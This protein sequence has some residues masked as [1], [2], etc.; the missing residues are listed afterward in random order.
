MS[1]VSGKDLRLDVKLVV[2]IAIIM[3]LLVAV[4]CHWSAQ[5]HQEQ[6]KEEL[7]SQARGFAQ[8]MDA[9]WKFVDVN[10]DLINYNFAGE[11]EYKQLHCSVAAKSVAQLFSAN[12]NYD[13]HYP[14]INPRNE[15]DSP[16]AWEQ[17]ALERFAEDPAATEY[18][19]LTDYG[20]SLSLRYCAPLRVDEGCL[21]CHGSPAGEIDITGYP[22][23]GWERGDLAGAIS[24]VIPAEDYINAYSQ[25]LARDVVFFLM[26]VFS[27]LAVVFVA[28][29]HLAT[30][31]LRSI[32]DGLE[33]VGRGELNVKLGAS[34]SSKEIGVVVSAFN[35]MTSELNDLYAN[36][37]EK[38]ESR[39][40]ALRALNDEVLRQK[41][42]VQRANVKLEQESAYK[43][44]FLAIMSHELKTPLTAVIT[45]LEALQSSHSS[46]S[47]EDRVIVMRCEANSREL[48]NIIS[49]IL[50]VSRSQE[51]RQRM[52]WET[53]DLFDVAEYVLSELEPLARQKS[54]SMVRE[55]DSG[56]PLVY[57]DW[58]KLRHILRNLLSN[59]IKFSEEG[60]SVTISMGP[61]DDEN[62][63]SDGVI[64]R[65]S[66][67][68]TGILPEEIDGIFD[69]FFQVRSSNQAQHDGTGLGLF[70]VKE[71]VEL[72]G[73]SVSVESVWGKGSTFTVSLPSNMD[74]RV[75]S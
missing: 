46:L 31:P 9:V 66:D 27:A 41:E 64:I 42:S 26:I 37:E 56:T 34:Q 17:A 65:V 13:I 8:Q 53:V 55:F 30:K 7:V 50:E 2:L 51:R 4:F 1:Y 24:I 15:K 22:K 29:R 47:E 48:L 67:H 61:M 60:E 39:T 71:F 45:Y 19:Q 59:A 73:G 16:D 14:R 5:T 6:M 69:R 25:A 28:V 11:F 38:V 62:P 40:E 68:G 36:L 12:A 70:I 44:E 57:A 10:Q 49:N 35:D 75:S 52:N 33:H 18:Y 74:K 20:D 32:A 72:H 58:E 23:E 63:E 43:S 54:L 21:Q 3:G